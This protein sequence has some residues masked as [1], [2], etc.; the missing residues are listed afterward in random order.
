MSLRTKIII[1]ASDQTAAGFGS[2]SKRVDKIDGQLDGVTNSIKAF[3]G[4]AGASTAFAGLVSASDSVKTM[5]S[6]LKL[7]TQSQQEFAAASEF[8]MATSL[9][10]NTSLS[11]NVDLYANLARSSKELKGDSERL[12]L[13]QSTLNRSMRISNRSAQENT[14]VIRQFTQAMASGVLRGQEFNSVSE[15]S[16]RLLQILTDGLGKTVGELREMANQGELTSDV[17][18]NAIESQ[19]EVV[20]QENEQI[21]R[22]IKKTWGSAVDAAS[23]YIGRAEG[24]SVVSTGIAE[25][26]QY[27]AENFDE[28]AA[29]AEIAGA[30]I[31]SRYAGKGL[32]ALQTYVAGQLAAVKAEQAKQ[33]ATAKTMQVEAAAATSK[34]NAAR[35]ELNYSRSKVWAAN[36]AGQAAAADARLLKARVALTAATRQASAANAAY[37]AA[38]VRVS[39]VSGV[40]R[41]IMGLM[42][43]PGGVV[44]LGAIALGSWALNARDAA[45]DTEKLA[46]AVDRYAGASRALQADQINQD[47][48]VMRSELKSVNAE[49]APYIEQGRDA[50]RTYG[51]LSGKALKIE[52]AIAAAKRQLQQL[53]KPTKT[54]TISMSGLSGET[55]KAKKASEDY[56]DKL[57]RAADPLIAYNEGMDKLSDAM[58]RRALSAAAASREEL[59]L[60]KQ[61]EDAAGI[62]E[63]RA[64]ALEKANQ[65][66]DE[67]L[68][69]VDAVADAEF[70]AAKAAYEYDQELQNTVES[71]D[72]RIAG[73]E[74]AAEIQRIYNEAQE[75]GVAISIEQVAADYDLVQSRQEIIDKQVELTDTVEGLVG[76]LV[77]AQFAGE[78]FGDSFVEEIKR[79][80]IEIA[81]SNIIEFFQWLLKIGDGEFNLQLGGLDGL[82]GGGGSSPLESIASNLLG[83]KV[84]EYV[85]A[86][87][88]TSLGLGGLK[89]GALSGGVAGN[90]FG[91]GLGATALGGGGT[92]AGGAS[93][94][95]AAAG[96]AAIAA[97][98]V[99]GVA[100]I[101]NRRRGRIVES[102]QENAQ[103]ATGGFSTGGVN[104]LGTK[105]DKAFAQT[106][107]NL[108]LY[109]AAV[110]AVGGEIEKSA[111]GWLQVGGNVENVAAISAAYNEQTAAAMDDR[112]D[113]LVYEQTR[114]L[115]REEAAEREVQI[116][117]QVAAAW[118]RSVDTIN[119]ADF[120]Q[121]SASITKATGVGT[122]ALQSLFKHGYA[123]AK[124]INAVFGP[125]AA[126]IIEK[127]GGMERITIQQLKSI[128]ETGKAAAGEIGG[129][130]GSMT[131]GM[132]TSM[133]GAVSGINDAIGEIERDVQVNV[134]AS[135]NIGGGSIGGRASG[136]LV[137]APEI[138]WIA[139]EGRELVL[140]NPVTEFF[141]KNGVPI[142]AGG[143]NAGVIKLLE[144]LAQQNER[145]IAA[146][147]RSVGAVKTLT[148]ISS[149]DAGEMK[150]EMAS[151]KQGLRNLQ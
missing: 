77:D 51:E 17:V 42:G 62:T 142:N 50:G 20:Q 7:A 10:T 76:N 61:Y 110:Q 140:P 28:V 39:R 91:G 83:K 46:T 116:R 18:I 21:E 70:E 122:Q 80:G 79:I 43:G 22:T 82:F 73:G 81:K 52:E 29:K 5:D 60:K 13:V 57:E 36:T 58:N 141:L 37:A 123:T 90:G 121:Y 124:G 149:Q 9:E 117:E 59:R 63:Q 151:I 136:G 88:A 106:R 95:A 54:A 45:D 101:G 6:Q 112:A 53:D 97:A 128:I 98:V 96:P 147:D 75:R 41:G 44:T 107:N 150:D 134:T 146:T 27:T 48:A 102:I 92:A 105:G 138:S 86:E 93:S 129:A 55:D 103:G 99:A 87:L 64:K 3:F 104:F 25:A 119:S 144:K 115:E 4:I 108:D 127:M 35:L 15:Q 31:A 11:A 69:Q 56:V 34:L 113:K 1:S 143:D 145:V 78:S 89:A 85:S 24:V 120:G 114:F 67:L 38:T 74:R 16:P 72:A 133:S 19:A 118:A 30:I 131:T 14:A 125:A 32:T 49:M 94:L 84:K 71:L 109:K 137:S 65:E 100:A 130:F 126:G 111:K 33:A 2:V 66:F 47:L 132:V 148:L 12:E 139:E 68:E 40:L 23:Q 135:T 8:V 26:L